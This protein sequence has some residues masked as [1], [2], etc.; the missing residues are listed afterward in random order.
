MRGEPQS[1]VDDIELAA[2]IA[3]ALQCTLHANGIT[4]EVSHRVVTLEGEADT[5]QQRKAAE[6]LARRFCED[7]RS[8]V[9][10]KRRREGQLS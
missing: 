2:A 1:A 7:V 6:M 5:E 3:V 9:R 4:V 8:L 10:T